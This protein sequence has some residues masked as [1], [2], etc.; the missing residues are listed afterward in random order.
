M[1]PIRRRRDAQAWQGVLTRFTQSGMS[2]PAFCQRERISPASLYRWRALLGSS[3]PSDSPRV[4][5]AADFVDLGTLAPPAGVELRLDLGGG[6]LLQL[7][8]R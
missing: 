4:V 6:L 2:A 7:T 5:S 3:A 1:Q 8:R